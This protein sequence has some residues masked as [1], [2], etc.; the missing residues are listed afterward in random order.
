M[1]TPRKGVSVRGWDNGKG[2]TV[3]SQEGGVT[4]LDLVESP[5]FT[6]VSPRVFPLHGEDGEGPAICGQLQALVGH[7]GEIVEDPVDDNVGILGVAGEGHILPLLCGSA[8]ADCHGG[9]GQQF[10]TGRERGRQKQT[11]TWGPSKT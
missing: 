11:Q 4:A 7:Q 1:G 5:G 9:S 2:L 8:L 10:C 3:H 6:S